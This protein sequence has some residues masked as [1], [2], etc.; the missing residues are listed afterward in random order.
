[1]SLRHQVQPVLPVAVA[2]QA[3]LLGQAGNVMVM[4]W[5]VSE[6]RMVA[7]VV[8]TTVVVVATRKAL[9]LPGPFALSGPATLAHSHL[10][11]QEI[12]K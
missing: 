1:M 6:A 10:L 8:V 7:V 11:M 3:A 12:H 2:V 5:V 4:M 9:A